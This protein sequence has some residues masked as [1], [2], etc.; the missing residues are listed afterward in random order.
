MEY[1]YRNS[2]PVGMRCPWW[3]QGRTLITLNQTMGIRNA[4]GTY[5]VVEYSEIEQFIQEAQALTSVG[6]YSKA[7]EIYGSFFV[8]EMVTAVP[9]FPYNQHV[10]INYACV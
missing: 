1:H 2:S 3:A 4:A 9:D 6:D 8:P 5:R 7:A 10:A